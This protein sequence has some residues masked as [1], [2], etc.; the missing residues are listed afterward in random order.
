MT[1]NIL[2]IIFILVLAVNIYP[3]RMMKL[4]VK[5]DGKESQVSYVA[6][7]NIVY[8]SAI[9]L[10]SALNANHYFN[11]KSAKVELKFSDYNLKF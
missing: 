2:Y 4:L 10:A 5:N 11:S 7:K 3:Q 9:E 8:V 6:R 1:K